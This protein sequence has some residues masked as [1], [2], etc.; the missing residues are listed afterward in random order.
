MQHPD[1]GAMREGGL[2]QLGTKQSGVGTVGCLPCE[3]SVSKVLRSQRSR[4]L[5]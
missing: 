3:N 4:G 2:Q 5:S 1:Q